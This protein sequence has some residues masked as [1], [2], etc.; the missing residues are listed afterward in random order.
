MTRARSERPKPAHSMKTPYFHL[1]RTWIAM[2]FPLLSLVR[3]AAQFVDV[4]AEVEFTE[5]HS[6]TVTPH[7]WAVR[8]VAGTNSW[9]MD[10]NFSSNA[11]TTYWFTGTNIIQYSVVNKQ[12]EENGFLG[13]AIGSQTRR[14]YASVDGNPGTLSACLPDGSRRNSGPDQLTTLGRIAW[15]AFCSGPCLKRDGRLIFPPSDL[16]KELICAPSGFSDRTT[17]F[18]DAFGLPK[19]VVLYTTNGQPVLQYSVTASTNVLGWEFPLEFYLAQY[20]PA[21]SPDSR[22]FGT[23]GWELQLTAK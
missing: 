16:W 13:A 2:L 5:W 19:N 14:I 8:C 21:Y 1:L 22:R 3:A 11:K 18:P 9:Q 23:N 6:G 12:L 20:R 10:G 7:L 17:V 4:S 15:L